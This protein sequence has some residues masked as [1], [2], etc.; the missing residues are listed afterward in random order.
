[1]EYIVVWKVYFL[2][3]LQLMCQLFHSWYNKMAYTSLSL[4]EFT[5]GMFKKSRI[6]NMHPK[7]SNSFST[8]FFYQNSPYEQKRIHQEMWSKPFFTRYNNYEIW[9]KKQ[10][11]SGSTN[12]FLL[13]LVIC[14]YSIQICWDTFLCII[15]LAHM[16]LL[17]QCTSNKYPIHIMET[18]NL[19]CLLES[20]REK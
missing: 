13:H 2:F 17:F 8:F 1:M 18:M 5:H 11:K 14:F 6:P 4:A 7:H 19:S 3:L 12:N 10:I 9:R 20:T 15:S 16:Y